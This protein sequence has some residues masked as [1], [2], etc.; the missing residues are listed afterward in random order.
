MKDVKEYKIPDYYFM[1]GKPK[2]VDYLDDK[3]K[4]LEYTP[5]EENQYELRAEG[6]QPRLVCSLLSPWIL[7]WDAPPANELEL[8]NVDLEQR[9]VWIRKVN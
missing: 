9:K 2:V 5:D 7:G 3:D 1:F 8:V 6:C 4:G